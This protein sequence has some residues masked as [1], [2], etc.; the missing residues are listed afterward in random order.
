MYI[1]IQI[2]LT[3]TSIDTHGGLHTA[4]SVSGV[5]T[6]SHCLLHTAKQELAPEKV[7]FEEGWES[8]EK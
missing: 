3:S 4:S 2:S 5:G 8:R 6:M 7:T 1:I